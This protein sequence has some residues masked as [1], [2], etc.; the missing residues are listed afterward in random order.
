MQIESMGATNPMT[1]LIVDLT[2]IDPDDSFST[3]MIHFTHKRLIAY[4]RID[5][6]FTQTP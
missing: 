5:I 4:P 2:G 1:C 6:D 3:V